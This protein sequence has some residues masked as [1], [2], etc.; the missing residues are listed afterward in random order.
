MYDLEGSNDVDPLVIR[1]NL[2]DGEIYLSNGLV[3]GFDI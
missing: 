3:I 1:S 2:F